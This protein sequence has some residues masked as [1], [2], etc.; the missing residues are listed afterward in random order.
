MVINILN[1]KVF[2]TDIITSIP[3]LQFSLVKEQK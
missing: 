3:V 1:K 2:A